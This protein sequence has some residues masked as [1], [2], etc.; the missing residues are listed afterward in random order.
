MGDI[1]DWAVVARIIEGVPPN[2]ETDGYSTNAG[3]ENGSAIDPFKRSK[4]TC[5]LD[6]E[7]PMAKR[8]QYS[9]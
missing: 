3:M 4:L 5:F 2:D 8:T 6:K 9:K 1:W 7:A